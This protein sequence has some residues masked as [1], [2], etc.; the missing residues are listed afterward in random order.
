[1]AVLAYSL[2]KRELNHYF[3]VKN[4]KL[5]SL[6]LVAVLLV[7]HSLS[8]YYGGERPALRRKYSAAANAS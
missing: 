1:M 2:G 7:S 6:A 5:V 8:R 4:A 3:T